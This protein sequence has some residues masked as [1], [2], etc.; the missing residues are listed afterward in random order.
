LND[1]EPNHGGNLILIEQTAVLPNPSKNPRISQMAQICNLVAVKICV[2][3][4]YLRIN[5]LQTAVFPN[6]H[7]LIF[8]HSQKQG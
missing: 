5:Y 6:S 2:N 1:N 8:P 4:R 7:S 3:L